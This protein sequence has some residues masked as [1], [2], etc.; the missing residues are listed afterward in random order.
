MSKSTNLNSEPS[1]ALSWWI[2]FSILQTRLTIT[3]K[4]WT[5][6]LGTAVIGTTGWHS[7]FMTS[8]WRVRWASYLMIRS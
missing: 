7:L 2:R 5:L 6:K 4:I 3:C 8:A 1:F